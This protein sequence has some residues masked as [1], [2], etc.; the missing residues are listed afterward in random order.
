VDECNCVSPWSW[1]FNVLFA[2]RPVRILTRNEPMQR[3]VAALARTL[4]SVGSVISLGGVIFLGFAVVGRCTLKSAET[5][6]E[7]ALVM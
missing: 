4:P 7:S 2:A 6:V 5:R 3:L 1:V